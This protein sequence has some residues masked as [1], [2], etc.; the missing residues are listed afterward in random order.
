MTA[1][2]AL[3]A[4]GW[5]EDEGWTSETSEDF[6]AFLDHDPNGCL[7]LEHDGRPA[8]VCVATVYG[9]AG[10][11]GEMIVSRAFRGLGLGP[12]LFDQ[13]LSYLRSQGCLSVSLDAVP[14][15][16]AFYETRG[17]RTISLSRRFH[18]RIPPGRG[19]GVWP[20]QYGDLAKILAVDLRAFG[21]DRS[22]FL[23]R[24][25]EQCP[26]LAWV[27][28]Q[29]GRIV[30]Y[31]FGR[32]RRGFCWAGPIWS[33]Q[34]GR[35]AAFLLRG[36]AL[37]AG[38]TSIQVGVLDIN[39]RAVDLMRRLGLEEKREPSRRMALGEGNPVGLQ[40]GLLAI[41]TAGKG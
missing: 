25:L 37:G 15:A 38:D 5:A 16:A 36:L 30:G 13:A 12:I 41:G 39:S 7:I 27:R 32:R 23:R 35:H 19:A 4:G 3:T 11:L 9:Q 8:A 22:F 33:A 40:P 21:A 10:F 31:I 1:A 14:K 34:A 18:G 26:E 2:D 20:M 28:L 6:L 29:E 17:F 24:R